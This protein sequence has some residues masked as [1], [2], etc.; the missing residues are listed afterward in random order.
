MDY[1]PHIWNIA[2]HLCILIQETRNMVHDRTDEY[3][4]IMRRGE[5]CISR[6]RKVRRTCRWQRWY[7]SWRPEKDMESRRRGEA[8]NGAR[9]NEC[10]RAEMSVWWRGVFLEGLSF[11]S[12][13]SA[14][15]GSSSNYEPILLSLLADLAF[16][17]LFRLG[18]AAGH[19]SRTHSTYCPFSGVELV[20]Y[21]RL[22][23][24][25]RSTR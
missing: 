23:A 8:E 2:S 18:P 12:S 19:R 10:K 7:R 4:S 5:K 13:G 1:H 25:S 11:V 24:K 21:D 16:L 6:T 17:F 20:S 22:E 3:V 9:T 15:V 14:L